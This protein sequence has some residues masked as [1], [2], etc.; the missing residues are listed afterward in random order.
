MRIAAALTIGTIV[1]LIA[2]IGAG[3]IGLFSIMWWAW[4]ITQVFIAGA[5]GFCTALAFVQ[6]GVLGGKRGCNPSTPD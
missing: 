3:S 6:H 4:I 1:L 5:A 2:R